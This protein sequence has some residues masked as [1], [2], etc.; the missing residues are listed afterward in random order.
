MSKNGFEER[1]DPTQSGVNLLAEHLVR[2]EF[3][4]QMTAGSGSPVYVDLGCG[5]GFGLKILQWRAPRSI[6]FGCDMS[7]EALAGAQSYLGNSSAVRL[8]QMDLTRTE[9]YSVFEEALKAHEADPR[10]IVCFEIV[11]HLGDFKSLITFVDEQ[12]KH[13]AEAFLSVPNDAFWGVRNPF[14]KNMFGEQAVLELM[15]LFDN[16]PRLYEQYPIQGA[17]IL[18]RGI[19]EIAEDQIAGKLLPEFLERRQKVS[20]PSHFILHL[21]GCAREPDTFS[22]RFVLVD[23]SAERQWVAQREAD[24]LYYKKEA[25]RLGQ[26]LEHL[27]QVVAALYSEVSQRE[28]DMLSDGK[29]AAQLKGEWE[30]FQQTVANLHAEVSQ[31]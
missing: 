4:S 26:K 21:G 11:E 10:V 17:T 2:Y 29:K 28:P 19:D 14:H 8:L 30:R 5:N 6:L 7:D 13:G 16:I 23:S 15:Q 9:N 12:V 25:S 24:M 20:V 22:A 1:V 18:P 27:Q 3:V 31:P